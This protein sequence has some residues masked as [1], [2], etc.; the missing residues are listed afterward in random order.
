MLTKRFN[1]A[2]DCILSVSLFCISACTYSPRHQGQS[3]QQENTQSVKGVQS[4]SVAPPTVIYITTT[5]LPKTVRAGK[6]LIQIDS[7]NGGAPFFTNYSSDQGLPSDIECAVADAAGNIWFASRGGGAWKYDGK[8]FTNY[9]TIQGLINAEVRC[10]MQDSKG[11]LWFGTFSGVSKYDG[12]S[13]TNYTPAQGL[14]GDVVQKIIEDK[15]GN[16]WFGTAT[17]VSKYDG[18][19]FINYTT[20]QGLPDN[21]VRN[22]IEDTSGN[23]WFG[24]LGGISKYNGK[25]FTNYTAAQGLAGNKVNGMI[26]DRSGNLW[27]GSLGG[28]VSRY[29]GKRF[30]NYTTAQ[31]LLDNNVNCIFQDRSGDI[32][33]GTRQGVSKYD[34]KTFTN[35]TTT[36]GLAA[37]DIF[38]ITEDRRG[39]LWFTTNGGGVSRYD[40][41]IVTYFTKTQ[42][43]GGNWISS[44]MQDKAGNLWIASQGDGVTRYDG[45]TFTVYTKSQ[46]LPDNWI[47]GLM[48]DK[49]GNIWIATNGGVSRFDG[50]NFTT[51]TKAQGLAD[52]TASRILQ[53][54]NGDIWF[55][56]LKGVSKFDGNKFTSYTTAQGL[57]NNWI[58]SLVQDK[59]GNVWMGTLGGVSKFDGKTF[60]NYSKAQGL[61]GNEIFGAIQDGYGNL[62]FGCDGAGATK[63]DGKSFT[64]F[65]LPQGLLHQ[66]WALVQD[67]FSNSIWFGGDGLS[68]LNL[69]SSIA[70]KTGAYSFD[71]FDQYNG[72]EIK[73]VNDGALCIDNKEILWAGGGDRLIRFDYSAIKKTLDPLN[74]DIENIKVNNENI[75]WNILDRNNHGYSAID[76]PALLNEMV[77]TFGKILSG[78]TLDSMRT[79]FSDL[80]FDSITRFYP[81]PLN[82][83]L[84]Y[85]DNNVSIEFVAIEPEMPKMVKYQY[86][87]EGNDKEWSPLSNNTL[88][89]F[90]NLGG[91]KYTFRLKALSPNGVWSETAY[92]F[93]VLPPWY[94]TW[95][96]R[97]VFVLLF[98][99]MVWSIIQFRS[100][101]LRHENR[102]LEEKVTQRTHELREEKEIAENTLTELKSTQALLIQSEKMASLGMLTAGIAHEIQNP[103]NFVNNF[104]EVSLELI[105][106][107]KENLKS[108][109][110][111]EAIVTAG[112]IEQNLQKVVIHGKRADAI[113]RGMLQHSRASTGQ[114]EPIDINALVDEYVRLSYQSLRTKDNSCEIMLR[115]DFDKS[116]GKTNIIPQDIGRVL[117]NLCN[118]AF[119]AVSEKKR[120]GADG[121]EP[122]V[123]IGTKNVN[124]KVEIIVKDNGNGIPQKIKDKIFQPFFTTKPPGQGTGLGL[125]LSYDIV[126]AHGGQLQVHTKE[127]EYAEFVIELPT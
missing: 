26:Q 113:V 24:T 120:Q 48:E 106:E 125:S 16:M 90:G 109:E 82:L 101:Q 46:G 89:V 91:G 86:K 87:L 32:W 21:H 111:S 112:D 47:G 57:A 6:P 78:M 73:D 118:N 97:S 29:D 50:R 8:T 62:W 55:G 110:I 124:G 108:D 52:N 27:L 40:G 22:I 38:S 7:S 59:S 67:T 56:T 102:I 15:S 127:G 72:Y 65:S 68:R 34:G 103:L 13:F 88:A 64:N 17:G 84:P 28:G 123:S 104:S 37:N 45:K 49:N 14:A 96:A 41:N 115:T 66:A 11:C 98:I 36:Q 60:T 77:T 81:V 4:D 69:Q 74:L 116:I 95:W 53:D 61:A 79:K 121:Y 83:V 5:N 70:D 71:N 43:L 85:S 10:V 107:M 54:R 119:Y 25:N 2:W 94:G 105:G 114:K 93:T 20:V 1:T 117:L 12:K 3:K 51:Y 19:R 75:C 92:K 35:Y 122:T 100:R 33:F 58:R 76:S 63:F 30:T 39:N 99:L 31:G 23:I 18:K 42:G 9:S 44:V 80:T 126:R